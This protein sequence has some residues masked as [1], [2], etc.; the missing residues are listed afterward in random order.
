M[1][2]T[3]D[4]EALRSDGKIAVSVPK[5]ATVIY[6][7]SLTNRLSSDGKIQPGG[8]TASTTFGGVAVR[9]AASGASHVETY[10]TGE[11]LF[12][13]GAGSA[14]DALIGTEVCVNGEDTV[15]VAGTTTN[16][17]KCGIIA[18]VPSATTVRVVIDGY[19]K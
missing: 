13:F 5:A 3:N 10:R 6:G 4:R 16:D 12:T 7:G 14:T 19:V 8:D 1:A 11:F 9:R 15:D 17:V 18:A 2:L